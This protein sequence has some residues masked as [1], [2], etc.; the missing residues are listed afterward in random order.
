[1]DRTSNVLVHQSALPQVARKRILDALKR[2]ELDPTLLYSGL[3][4]TLHWI[5]LHHAVSPAK[6][7]PSFGT[8][9]ESAF[10]QAAELCRG[11]VVHVISLAC[12]DGTKDT[13][14][15]QMVRKSGKTVIYTPADL[16]LEMVLTA[17][18]TATEALR[19]LQTTPLL[20]ELGNCSVLPAIVKSFDP[21]GA[22][23][24]VLFLGTIHN[25]WP[26][27]ILRSVT[28]PVRSQDHLLIGANLAPTAN[29]ENVLQEILAQYDNAATRN[30]LWGALSELAIDAND[31][32]LEFSLVPADSLPS[33]KRIQADF[34]FGRARQLNFF[35]ERIDFNAGEKLRIFYSYRYTADH[36]RGFLNQARLEMTEE[37][38]TSNEQ[39]GLFLCRRSREK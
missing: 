37:W 3:R 20:C 18:Q 6:I 19:G 9:Y 21:S 5:A 15:L 22:E 2:Q 23:R 30:W 1:M 10:R 17:E 27:D 38:I 7:D 25:F 11:N 33:L 31:G 39:E 36:I 14:C 29:Y 28:Y 26:L 32:Q 24:L 34:V 13:Q 16:S 4:Q 35:G 12:G 8:I